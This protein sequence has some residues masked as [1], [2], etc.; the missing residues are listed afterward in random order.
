MSFGTLTI[1][2]IICTV[3]LYV[4]FFRVKDDDYKDQK[5]ILFSE[6][7]LKKQSEEGKHE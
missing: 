1:I 3:V 4:W 6:E 5:N 2:L 7:E